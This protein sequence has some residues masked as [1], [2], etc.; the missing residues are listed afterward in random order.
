M[1]QDQE[2][3]LLGHQAGGRQGPMNWW[4]DSKEESISQEKRKGKHTCTTFFFVVE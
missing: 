2:S 4:A 1:G 3:G